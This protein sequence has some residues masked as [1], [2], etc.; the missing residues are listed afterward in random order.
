MFAFLYA[1]LMCTGLL[2][3]P[4]LDRRVILALWYGLTTPALALIVWNVAQESWTIIRR[5]RMIDHMLKDEAEK[6]DSTP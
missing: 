2:H 4:R 6:V 3:W 5:R 1:F